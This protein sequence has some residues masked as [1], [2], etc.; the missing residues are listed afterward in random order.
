MQSK[1]L[2]EVEQLILK[3]VSEGPPL[4]LYELATQINQQHGPI[5]ETYRT[6]LLRLVHGGELLI[7]WSWKVYLPYEK[8]TQT[9][10]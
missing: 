4:H 5:T 9:N 7:D 1:T 6:A 3:E 8:D 2:E 10:D